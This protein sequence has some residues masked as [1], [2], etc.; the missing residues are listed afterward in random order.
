MSGPST[1]VLHIPIHFPLS[2]IAPEA[3]IA[4]A[5]VNKPNRTVPDF[6]L[7]FI[8]MTIPFGN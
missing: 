4:T 2:A 3:I 1:L 6:V 8:L 5:S 7:P